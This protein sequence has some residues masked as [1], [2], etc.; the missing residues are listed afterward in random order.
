MQYFASFEEATK[1][2]SQDETDICNAILF[3][4]LLE[5]TLYGQIALEA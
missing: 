2:Q 4:F 3:I 1:M 5:H